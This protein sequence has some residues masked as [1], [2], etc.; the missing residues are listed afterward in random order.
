M[1]PNGNL[2]PSVYVFAKIP[3]TILN[4]EPTQRYEST[5]LTNA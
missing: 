4:G 1:Y 3:L 2:H 5:L